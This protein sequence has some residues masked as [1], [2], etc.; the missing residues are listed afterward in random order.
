[1]AYLRLGVHMLSTIYKEQLHI[2]A[3]KDF[4]TVIKE[5]A[6]FSGDFFFLVGGGCMVFLQRENKPEEESLRYLKQHKQK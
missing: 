4:V 5:N 1:M 3:F 6:L 2:I